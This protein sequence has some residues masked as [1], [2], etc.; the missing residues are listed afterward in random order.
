M[1]FMLSL[2]KT[3]A[4]QNK[5]KKISFNCMPIIKCLTRKTKHYNDNGEIG[6][7]WY[8]KII[9]SFKCRA[10]MYFQAKTHRKSIGRTQKFIRS[11]R[12][13]T[14]QISTKIQKQKK[15]KKKLSKNK[16]AS[17]EEHISKTG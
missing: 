2:A 6:V 3:K 10:V 1:L 11:L 17:N 9:Y 15:S 16:K 4:K 14:S 7:I 12:A 13:Y 5:K 8:N